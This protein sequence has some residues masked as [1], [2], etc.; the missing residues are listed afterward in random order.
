MCIAVWA[1]NSEGGTN[2]YGKAEDV[3]VDH[4]TELLTYDFATPRVNIGLILAVSVESLVPVY[5]H[6][7]H[8]HFVR[9]DNTTGQLLNPE[10]LLGAVAHELMLIQLQPECG[11]DAVALRVL[12]GRLIR[13][14]LPSG[15]SPG[16]YGID[17]YVEHADRHAADIPFTSACFG[18]LEPRTEPYLFGLSATIDGCAFQRLISE[19][20]NGRR[21]Y[22]YSIEGPAVVA[23]DIEPLDLLGMP[24]DIL[25]AYQEAN[26]KGVVGCAVPVG[27][28]DVITCDRTSDVTNYLRLFT[29]AAWYEANRQFRFGE[30]Q[31]VINAWHSDKTDFLILKST[32]LD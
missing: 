20:R 30:E 19:I 18:P 22:L 24:Q 10:G 14:K 15:E 25:G 5:L 32:I 23:R 2:S 16:Y 7:L 29:R 9:L 13:G 1:E 31:Y 8:R 26:D 28:Y 21:R 17:E 3:R 27:S 6:A 12:N 4:I 11:G